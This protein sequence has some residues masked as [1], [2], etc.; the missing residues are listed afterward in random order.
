MQKIHPYPMQCTQCGKKSSV[1]FSNATEVVE[2]VVRCAKCGSEWSPI[3]RPTK[4]PSN[5]K[6]KKIRS[7]SG[8]TIE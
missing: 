2:M 3:E 7:E 4:K 5:D 6:P 8:G 1:M